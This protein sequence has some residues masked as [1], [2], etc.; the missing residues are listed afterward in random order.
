LSRYAAA[1]RFTGLA[2]ANAAAA[3]WRAEVNGVV[4]SEI[5]AVPAEQL[6]IERDL[7]GPLLSLRASIGRQVTRKVDR[8]WCVEVARALYS[9][10]KE[11]LG[12]H[13]DARAGSALVKLC[14]RGQLV[15][16]HPRQQP[17]RRSTDPADLPA[18]K[19]TYAMRDVA[20]LAKA[21]RRHGDADFH[22][23]G[24][25]FR[26]AIPSAGVRASGSSCCLPALDLE[27]AAAPGPVAA[28]RI[29]G[30]ARL[31]GL[32]ADGEGHYPNGLPG[33]SRL[34]GPG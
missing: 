6:V 3:A 23:G 30:S 21:A 27:P 34:P 11:Y 8:L 2:A 24:V 9:A 33:P 15:K 20:S 25:R 17:G 4:H 7:L 26:A 13:L 31:R 18:E 16:V 29:R 10:P 12:C 28:R 1:R 22:G 14:C 5:C 32:T 19:T